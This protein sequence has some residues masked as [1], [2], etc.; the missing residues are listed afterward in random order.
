MLTGAF[1]PG[2][3]ITQNFSRPSYTLAVSGSSTGFNSLETVTQQINT[4]SNNY[5]EVVSS[6][7][8][9]AV[10]YTSGNFVNSAI[11]ANLS[12]TV[13]SNASSSQVNGTLNSFY[14]RVIDKR[15]YQIFRKQFAFPG[16]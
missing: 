4:S 5:G 14:I 6:N 10:L 1:V 15:L 12:G 3:E 13:T 11:G 8:S 16:R 2:E 9:V 7:T